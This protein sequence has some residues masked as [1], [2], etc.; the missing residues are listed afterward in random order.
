MGF[1]VALGVAGGVGVVVAD[2]DAC[3]VIVAL[4]D[5]T[6]AWRCTGRGFGVLTIAWLILSNKSFRS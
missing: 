1:G 5:A 3:G 6:G 4:G 2:G